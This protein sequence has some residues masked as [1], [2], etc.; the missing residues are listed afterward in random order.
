MV[1]M[2]SEKNRPF[3]LSAQ[4]LHLYPIDT[5]MYKRFIWRHF[6]AGGKTIDDVSL[7]SIFTWSR[8]QTYCI[9]LV[10]NKLYGRY[11]QVGSQELGS[12]YAEILDQESAL[13]SEYT[14]LLSKAQWKVLRAV[15]KDEPVENPLSQKFIGKYDL[16]AT[17]TVSTALEMLKRN[18]IVIK[19]QGAYFIHEVLLTRW[20]QSL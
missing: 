8:R 15:A 17:S 6:K 10:C 9:Q 5:Q 13:F 11:N 19:D 20:L 2:F 1:S 7:E 14:R 3:Y 16:G 12:V 4:L 18:E